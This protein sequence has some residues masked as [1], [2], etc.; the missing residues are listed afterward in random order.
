M[1]GVLVAVLA[2]ALAPAASAGG[3]SLQVGAAEDNV[4]QATLVGAKAKM[5][6]AQLA[7]LRALRVTALW[8]PGLEEPPAAERAA[9]RNALDA[10]GPAGIELVVSVYP[11]GSSVTPLTPEARREFATFTAAVVDLGFRQVI[12]GNEP[13]LNRFWLPQFAPDGSN[14][15]A[16]AFL[17]LLAETYDA[18]KAAA[19]GRPTVVWGVGLSP[20]G[21]DNPALS[22]HTHSPTAFIRDLGVA[23]RAT[24]RSRPIMDGLAIHPYGDNSSQAPRASAHPNSTSI[25]LADYAKL[26]G[27]LGEA[28]DG[29]AQ[30]GSTLPLLY[31]EYGVEAQIPAAK[32]ALYE[33]P[34]PATTRPVD[35]QTQAR[36]YREAIEMT[37]CQPNVRGIF[38]FHTVDEKARGAWQSGLYALDETPRQARDVVRTATEHVRRGIV[39]RCNLQL[40][41]RVALRRL[42]DPTGVRLRFSSSLDATYRVRLVRADGSVA[43]SAAGRIVGGTQKVVRL[44]KP[45]VPAGVFRF[46]VTARAVAN[47][48]P[49]AVVRST[50]FAIR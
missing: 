37:F 46:E 15:A 39:A 34:E 2:L 31:D 4:K 41:P 17:P 24:G 32:E 42:P 13:N 21:S 30:A 19:P 47:P 20:R 12:V 23:Y 25:G 27:L 48:G 18:V 7:G 28:F 5:T 3:P 36:F 11:F 22:R 45:R 9:L 16:T 26:V 35:E 14:A 43:G 10:A 6:L 50:P 40:T 29:T 1:K 33:G 8:R 49:A 38:L 44:A